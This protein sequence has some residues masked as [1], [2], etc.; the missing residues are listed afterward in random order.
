MDILYS[1]NSPDTHNGRHSE[2]SS[3]HLLSQPF[4]LPAGVAENDGLGDCQGLV[5]IAEGVQFPL[6][7]LN[8]KHKSQQFELDIPGLMLNCMLALTYLDVELADTLQSQLLFLDQ[9]ADRFT[10]ELLG[11]L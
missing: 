9:D 7:T 10:H 8:L 6:F 3:V 11:D 1:I 5:Q 2:V 4:D